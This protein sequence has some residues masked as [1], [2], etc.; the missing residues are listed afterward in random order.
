MRKRGSGSGAGLGEAS[1]M[2]RVRRSR[3]TTLYA[4]DFLDTERVTATFEFGG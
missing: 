1:Y 4:V 3:P 2:K